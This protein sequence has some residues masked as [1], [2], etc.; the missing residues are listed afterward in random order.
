MSN[1]INQI[2]AEKSVFNSELV[3]TKNDNTTIHVTTTVK[4]NTLNDTMEYSSSVAENF[5][6][7]EK[8]RYL[9]NGTYRECIDYIIENI[10]E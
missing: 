8:R 1:K 6:R 10:E 3:L 7:E 4:I 5:H 9:F 2:K